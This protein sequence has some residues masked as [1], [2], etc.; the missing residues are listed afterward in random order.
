MIWGQGPS[1]TSAISGDGSPRP[2]VAKMG[3]GNV[4]GDRTILES[5]PQ[6]NC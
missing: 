6:G 1:L 5:R 3:R 4:W 2:L